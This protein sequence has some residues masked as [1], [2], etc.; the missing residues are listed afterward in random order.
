MKVTIDLPPG[1]LAAFVD[2]QPVAG[3]TVTTTTR[4]L[5]TPTKVGDFTLDIVT[6]AVTWTAARGAGIDRQ[7]FLLFSLLL[8][9]LPDSPSMV[10]DAVQYYGD[11]TIVRW[12]E[13]YPASGV[14]PAN[15]TPVLS[16]PPEAGAPST[17]ASPSATVGGGTGAGTTDTTAR[18]LGAVS[19]VL[20]GLGVSAG[21]FGLR[22]R[23]DVGRS[24]Q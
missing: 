1:T 23:R 11:G 13:P 5:P 16:L 14:E 2:T 3:W 24:G 18:L 7:Q 10:F 15:P 21:A 8:G 4:T 6:R 9:P 17:A 12:D 22:R 20:G 19:L